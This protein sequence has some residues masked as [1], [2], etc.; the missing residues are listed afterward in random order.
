[1]DKYLVLKGCA[2]IG[3]RFIT[4]MKAIQ[5][6]KLSRRIIYVDWGDG[7]FDNVGN[8]I[9]EEYFVFNYPHT[10]TLNDLI[11][12]LKNGATTYPKS[13]EERDF[14]I[15]VYPE[16]NIASGFDVYTPRIAH[17]TIYK[18]GLSIIPLHKLV[19]LLGLQSFQ[20][21]EKMEKMSWWK[22]VNT[23]YDGKNFPLGSN[24]WP[25]LKADIVFF[26]DFRPFVSMKNFSHYVNLREEYQQIIN[27][28]VVEM[29][30]NEAVGVH[31]RYTDKKPTAKL[32]TLMD[33][34]DKLVEKENCRIFLCTDNADVEK[35]FKE[36]YGNHILTTNKY[37]PKVKQGGI[38]IWA[39][40]QNDNN[41]KRRMFEDSLIDMWLLSKCK[42]LY[43]QG[44]SS[45]SYIS[46]LLMNDSKRC[47]D[48]TKM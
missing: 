7:M 2:G 27:G 43:W 20:R 24:L 28:K 29:M 42:Y 44:N 34:L 16:S 5:Y 11:G 14:Y 38:H 48:W 31:I 1:M 13:I 46:S 35:E 6:A 12:A 9:F 32:A 18:V 36:K 30:L 33:K 41:L 8:N 15:P 26:A 3:N 37:I 40:Q 19:Y 47:I 22:M 17:K 23:M 39:S 4:L 45:F 25:W 10:A 21:P